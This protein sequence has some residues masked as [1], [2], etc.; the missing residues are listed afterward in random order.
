MTY[1]KKCLINP[2]RVRKVVGSFSWVDRTL[3]REGY[4]NLLCQEAMLLYFFLI[5]VSDYQ[6]LSFYGD[7]RV[8]QILKLNAEA[9]DK[10]RRQLMA[11]DLIAYQHPMYQVLSLKSSQRRVPA[12]PVSHKPASLKTIMNSSFKTLV[13][14]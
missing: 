11:Q 3:M 6:G 10:G 1:L 7:Q 2:D 13:N 5:M 14:P 4:L 8:C 9:L 12:L